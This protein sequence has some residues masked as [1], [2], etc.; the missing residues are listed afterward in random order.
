MGGDFSKLNEI[1]FGSPSTHTLFSYSNIKLNI[2]TL[3]EG[4]RK[5]DKPIHKKEFWKELKEENIK[6]VISKITN[7][8]EKFI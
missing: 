3:L 2:L 6:K 4:E 5:V 1:E 8:L 7:I